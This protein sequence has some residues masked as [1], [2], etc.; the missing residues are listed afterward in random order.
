MMRGALVALLNLEPDVDVVSEV[1][2]GEEIIP[3]IRELHPDVAI[4]DIDLPGR[5]GLS[6]AAEIHDAKLSTHTLILT[7]LSRP[8]TIRRA[9]DARVDGYLLKDAPPDKLANAVRRIAAGSRV[10][11]NDLA[12]AAW[13]ADECPLTDRELSVLRL[14]AGG[15]DIPEIAENLFLSPGTVRNY[16]TAVVTKLDARNRV[17]AIRIAT[18]AGWL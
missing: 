16:L 15:E 17:D 4:I 11:D 8:G 14:A 6:V 3:A 9:L 1:S 5:D 2:T 12:A 7:N 10:V 18:D 13:R